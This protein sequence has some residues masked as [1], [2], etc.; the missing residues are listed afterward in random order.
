MCRV[1]RHYG[2][3][4]D[5]G[6][7]SARIEAELA[8]LVTRGNVSVDD[9]EA[10]QDDSYTL[11]A[12]DYL[13]LLD[14]AWAARATDPT[15][16]DFRDRADLD[17]L[18]TRLHGWDRRMERTSSEAVVFH[19]FMFF[20]A[21]HVLRD[22]LSLLFQPILEAES[23]YVLKWLSGVML[24]TGP[25]P[26]AAL[27]GE[28]REAAL[29]RALDRTAQWLGARFPDGDYTWGELHGTIFTSL[30]GDRLSSAWAPTDGSCGTLNRADTVFFASADTPHERLDA[31]DGS[32]YRMVATFRP[33]G[34]PQAY[35]TMGQGVSGDPESPHW[36][37][38]RADWIETHHR[39]LRF[40]REEVD[41]APVETLVLMP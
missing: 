16:V 7:R 23:A 27:D 32:I 20:L 29:V 17:A 24:R 1:V 28:S 8:R 10:L 15:L 22:D 33:D 18:V 14:A 40:L 38:L 25:H 41:A 37:D 31:S 12:D 30:Y 5:P 4:F 26:D 35:F 36:D 9:M 3:F 34:T 19:A 21:D 11:Y 2:V 13:P 39:P 6:V